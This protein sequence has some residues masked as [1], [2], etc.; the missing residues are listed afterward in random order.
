MLF[1][2]LFSHKLEFLHFYGSCHYF[3]ERELTLQYYINANKILFNKKK[4]NYKIISLKN[5]NFNLV[6][7]KRIWYY[8][9]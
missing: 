9:G 5:L 6:L 4:N 7:N 2:D 8:V 1:I 3:L